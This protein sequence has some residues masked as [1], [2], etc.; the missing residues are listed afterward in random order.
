[1]TERTYILNQ[2]QSHNLSKLIHRTAKKIKA[3]GHDAPCAFAL[4]L[5]PAKLSV[6]WMV[7]LRADD[8][9]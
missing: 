7:V 8:F 5:M 6:D 4:C 2:K 3:A 1:M 9:S